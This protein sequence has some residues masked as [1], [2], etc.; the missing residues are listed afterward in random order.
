MDWCGYS[1]QKCAE[2]LRT[3]ISMGLSVNE[4]SERLLRFGKNTLDSGKSSGVLKRFFSQFSDFMVLILLAA[5]AVSFVTAIFWGGDLTDPIMILLI[6]FLNAFIGTIQECRAENAAEALKKL[7]APHSKV[8]RG[9][10]LFT[11]AS[12][13]L[14][15]GDVIRIETGDLVCA[16]ARLISSESLSV[17]EASL[18]GES[19]PSEK[20]HDVILPEGTAA[21]D[22]ANMVFSSTIVTSGHADAVVTETGMDTKVGKIASLISSEKSP[23]TPLQKSLA[24]TGKI[25]GTAALSICALIF[26]LGVI[27]GAPPLEMFM[28][29]VSLA[30]AAIP[31]G[32]PA[33]VTIVLALGVRKM[34]VHRAI[35]RRLPAVETLGSTTV[36]C[37]D[38]T[39]TLT[40][41]KMT[42]SELFSGGTVSSHSP[43]GKEL[44]LLGA[45]CC[46][47]TLSKSGR[48]FSASGSPTENAI[49]IAAAETG[50]DPVSY[51]KQFRRV[52][53]IPF[54]SKRKRM[55]TVH[56]LSGGGYRII[57]KGAPDILLPL[58]SYVT[59]ASG[60]QA[61]GTAA[62]KRILSANDSMAEK[63]MRVIAVAMKDVPKLPRD[64]SS[65]E[66][67]LC[68]CGLIGMT[69][70]PRTQAKA[71]VARCKKAGI[72]P[73]MIT[74]DH[75]TTA[76]AVAAG[77]GIFTKNDR[78]MTGAELDR[79][80]Q[81]QLEKE[82][83]SC[84]VFARVSPEHKVRIVK[85]FQAGGEVA[86]MTGDGVND[87]PALKC[88]DIG[89]A[90]GMSGTDAAKSAADM[91]LTDDNFSTIVE[92]VGQGRGIFENIKKTVHFLLSCNIGEILTVLCGY[93]M[94][95]PSP[96]LAIQLLWVNLVTDSM[97]ALALGAEPVEDDIMERPPSRTE[98]GIFTREL[99]IRMILEGCL[100]GALAFLGFTIGRIFF[101]GSGEPV[102]GRTMCFAV[103]SMSQLVHSFNLKSRHISQG[104]GLFRHPKLLG[105][106]IIGSVMQISVIVLP[107]FNSIFHTA[108]LSPVQ[109]LTVA[110]LSLCPVIT[111]KLP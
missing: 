85:A 46:N 56:S 110:L 52:R 92:A 78:A 25:L 20:H 89:C 68:F 16:D 57:V 28:L 21:G 36:I 102:I 29:S 45:L 18:T 82:V 31:E 81:E 34:A 37:S 9:G 86:A 84:S 96:L 76:K 1:S 75:I 30:V 105:A 88:A 23:P 35:V 2:K 100:I 17:D 6:V 61:L 39:G 43:E 108:P 42:V 103:L 70:P 109:W 79:L 3:D 67:E 80:T 47:S 63:A 38:K 66:S 48:E 87:A 74:G 111:G 19:V 24:K 107:F 73:V 10:K 97:P 27:Q 40:K 53:E 77:L 7:S 72:R 13:E 106:F 83:R 69:D 59:G 90:M 65:L 62:R 51:A 15:P 8:I 94:K 5:A 93:L 26:L 58:C 50:Y 12:E 14:V 64:D 33:V 44:L 22:M 98:K 71:A 11:V 55:A 49:I 54:D 99:T 60:K 101:D 91:I 104:S 4:A 32:L 95:L 41:G